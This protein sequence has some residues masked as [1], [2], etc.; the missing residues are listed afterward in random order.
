MLKQLYLT[1]LFGS[2][3]LAH[4]SLVSA[5]EVVKTIT[6]NQDVNIIQKLGTLWH[7]GPSAAP[8]QTVDGDSD[9]IFIT[10]NVPKATDDQPDGTNTLVK[11]INL[12]IHDH[13]EGGDF[14]I[15]GYKY[16]T[17]GNLVNVF[18]SDTQLLPQKRAGESDKWVYEDV[19]TLGPDEKCGNQGS[20]PFTNRFHTQHSLIPDHEGCLRSHP[21]VA[22]DP[23]VDENSKLTKA[24]TFKRDGMPYHYYSL[25]NM[26]VCGRSDGCELAQIKI[27]LKWNGYSPTGYK[28]DN[29]HYHIGNINFLIEGD[30]SPPKN[31]RCTATD[32]VDRATPNRT[33]NKLKFTWDGGSGSG[34]V[35]NITEEGR[36]WDNNTGYFW[37]KWP[38]YGNDLSIVKSEFTGQAGARNK[39]LILVPGMTYKAY[40]WDENASQRSNDAS[41]K[42]EWCPP[43]PP[44]GGGKLVSLSHFCNPSLQSKDV[45]GNWL[46]YTYNLNISSEATGGCPSTQTNLFI[47]I[48]D[49]DTNA[50]AIKTY[51]G[52]PDY[53]YD[54]EQG[55]GV[56]YIIQTVNSPGSTV[57]FTW[58]PSVLIGGNNRSINQLVNYLNTN[59][60]NPYLAVGANLQYQCP[61]QPLA[62]I[63]WVGSDFQDSTA[64]HPAGKTELKPLSCTKA[65]DTPI[66]CNDEC[67]PGPV[68]DAQ[69]Q[70]KANGGDPAFVCSA[71]Q[72]DKCRLGVNEPDPYCKPADY[73]IKCDDF[74]TSDEQCQDTTNNG[75]QN[76]TCYQTANEGK[77]CRLENYE[78]SEVCAPSSA[79]IS[80]NFYVTPNNTCATDAEKNII[81]LDAAVTLNPP[82]EGEDIE[83]QSSSYTAKV[84]ES[85]T[86]LQ[87][88]LHF[89]DSDYVCAS[90]NSESATE[91]L[92]VTGYDNS[93]VYIGSINPPKNDAHFYLR[94]VASLTAEP[95]WQTWGGLVYG[96]SSLSSNLPT[97]DV[98]ACNADNNCYPYLIRT[99]QLSI[100]KSA[101]IPITNGNISPPSIL[102][103]MTLHNNESKYAKGANMKAGV[104]L[105]NFDYFK[106]KVDLTGVKTIDTSSISNLTISTGTDREGAKVF[107]REGDLVVNPSSTWDVGTNKV[108]IFVNGNLTFSQDA[109]E[110]KLIKVDNSGFLAFFVSGNVII[111]S[112]VGNDDETDTTANIE[113]VVVANG[114]ITTESE[115]SG[116]DKRLV[117]EGSYVGWNGIDL[118]RAVDGIE[119]KTIPSE[120]FIHRPDFVTNAPDILKAT[121]L[122][123]QEVN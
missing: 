110:E 72:G 57:N 45:V 42:L 41:C 31:L 87:P 80:G 94:D 112:N 123:W 81:T 104:T 16:D 46:A 120:L 35:F 102:G 106:Q 56:G 13:D 51:L 83:T 75:N 113:A 34:L 84:P 77:R 10:I 115:G 50:T 85:A 68:G 55:R 61:G 99:A 37:N 28:H 26:P 108:I 103:F 14:K 43:T 92:K 38:T 62:Q 1:I 63:D 67:T 29:F 70:D 59:G 109:A 111:D 119:S 30:G 44:P 86:E 5:A 93:C 95:W 23:G 9:V 19:D 122:N 74:C 114:K 48:M 7:G 52:T 98:F 33:D 21:V 40:V 27:K 78:E 25:E 39:P 11:G 82:T 88:I 15:Y 3:F 117:L 100:A 58:N 60:F 69:C 6:Y 20:E 17:N 2:L 12:T 22:G 90:C 4:T 71:S 54:G 105:E 89:K 64:G 116:L 18:G 66:K 107:H 53:V 73:S 121:T 79:Q 65:E 96:H 76:Y 24:G 101:G 91:G 36:S 97:D 8:A 47:S 118:K 49:G 32:C